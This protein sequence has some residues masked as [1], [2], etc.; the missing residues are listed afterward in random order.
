VCIWT[1][2]KDLAQCVRGD[3][4]VQVDRRTQTLRDAGVYVRSMELSRP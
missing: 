2:D 4:V 1:R 3:H